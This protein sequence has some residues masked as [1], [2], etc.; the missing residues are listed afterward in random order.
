ML[1]SSYQLF[2]INW[3]LIDFIGIIL[4]IELFRYRRR[5]RV[6]WF[7]SRPIWLTSSCCLSGEIL[8]YAAALPSWFY[9]SLRG[10]C[11]P[12]HS[13]DAEREKTKTLSAK[14]TSVESLMIALLFSRQ[15]VTSKSRLGRTVRTGTGSSVSSR[16]DIGVWNRSC[17]S[18]RSADPA[19]HSKIELHWE[20]VKVSLLRRKNSS[21]GMKNPHH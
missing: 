4:F 21:M 1:L 14:L 19:N 20:K 18:G 12:S 15:W 16:L 13:K 8:S 11:E 6:I 2:I 7:W 17:E 9:I 5:N 10:C 3:P